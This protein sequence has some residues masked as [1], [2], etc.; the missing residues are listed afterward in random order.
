MQSLVKN[1]GPYILD[2]NNY[3]VQESYLK[4]ESITL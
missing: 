4:K 1:I 3:V 2:E